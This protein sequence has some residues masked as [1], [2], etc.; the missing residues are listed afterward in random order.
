MGGCEAI[1]REFSEFFFW[2]IIINR[3]FEYRK[4]DNRPMKKRK[5]WLDT[6]QSEKRTRDQDLITMDLCPWHWSN[7]RRLKNEDFFSNYIASWQYRVRGEKKKI[8]FYLQWLGLSIEDFDYE[9]VRMYPL[10]F[11]T[12]MNDHFGTIFIKNSL[13]TFKAISRH[14]SVRE[15]ERVFN[16]ILRLWWR[17]SSPRFLED[18]SR[19]RSIRSVSM[20]QSNYINWNFSTPNKL[21]HVIESNFFS[22]VFS[23]KWV[24]RSE[25]LWIISPLFSFLNNLNWFDIDNQR[26]SSPG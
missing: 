23:N 6:N 21:K 26:I 1:E 8:D 3:L 12:L 2:L 9:W 22:I 24:P 13:K 10:A 18:S 19:S 16:A 15:R 5:L 17:S 14:W 25:S 7:E 11:E 20:I 4:R